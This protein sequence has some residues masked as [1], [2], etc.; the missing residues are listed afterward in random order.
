LLARYRAIIDAYLRATAPPVTSL[1][2]RMIAYHM[3]WADRHGRS[4]TPAA[5]K[6]VRPSLCL[7]ACEACGGEVTAALP[8]AAA[9]EWT[10]N[11]TLVHDDI[12]DGDRE[13]RHRETVWSLWGAAQ[14]INAGDA[15]HALASMALATDG[16]HP[17]RRLRATHSI[18]AATL[19]VIDGQCS[20]LELEGRPET[21]PREYRRMIRAKTGALLGASLES[22]AI[23]AGAEAR[24][25]R[26]FRAAGRLLGM[27]FQVR[28]DWLGMWG[29][30]EIMGKSGGTDIGR[31]KVTYPVVAGYAALREPERARMRELFRSHSP[32]ADREIRRLLVEAGGPELTRSTPARFAERAAATLMRCELGG[33]FID[34]FL[35]VARYVANRPR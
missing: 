16:A 6:L 28:D 33:R 3:G 29:D 27:A 30:P 9:L 7:W 19:E 15:L 20:D 5:G 35:E 8:A 22:G 18:S 2:G 13:R 21:S 32:G 12:Q 1:M 11:F 34:E 14:G 4:C 25:A 10:H 17:A 24:T 23:I 31:R 26:A